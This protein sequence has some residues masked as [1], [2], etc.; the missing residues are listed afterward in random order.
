MSRTVSQSLIQ[1]LS[2]WKD[3]PGYTFPGHG[4]NC[5]GWMVISLGSLADAPSS[6]VFFVITQAKPC[7]KSSSIFKL[8]L[9]LLVLETQCDKGDSRLSASIS[10]FRAQLSSMSMSPRPTSG[11]STEEEGSSNSEKLRLDRKSV[12]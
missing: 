5:Y 11:N 9:Q 10:E 2:C 6:L 3:T 1:G 4:F 12:V 8:F 7:H